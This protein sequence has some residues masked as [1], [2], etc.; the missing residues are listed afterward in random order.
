M[1]SHLPHRKDANHNEIAGY[2][3]DLG[4]SVFDASKFGD[5]FPDI[6]VGFCGQ[7]HLVEIKTPSGELTP[8]QEGLIERWRGTIT[9]VGTKED[10]I[11]MVQKYR[12]FS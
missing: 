4:C 12:K 2:F 8:A 11:A 5:G 1:R 9:V 6:V 10:V 7:N 3:T